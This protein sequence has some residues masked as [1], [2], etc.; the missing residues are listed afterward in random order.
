M[1]KYTALIFI[2]FVFS[3]IVPESLAVPF[4]KFVSYPDNWI[5]TA[6]PDRKVVLGG[7]DGTG[8]ITL[9][10][11]TGT[12]KAT[13]IEATSFSGLDHGDL[14]GLSDDDHPQYAETGELARLDGLFDDHVA[15]TSVHF[16]DPGFALAASLQSHE[17]DTGI[18]W[19]DPG[20]ALIASLDSHMADTDAHG[21]LGDH[22]SL[23]GLLDYD[24]PQYS[25]ASHI[26][27]FYDMTDVDVFDAPVGRSIYK[28][29]DG[30]WHDEIPLGV[31][32]NPHGD[33][34]ATNVVSDNVDGVDI[35]AH[36]T[37]S[38]AHHIQGGGGGGLWTDNTTYIMPAD[39]TVDLG[40]TDDRIPY[41]YAD[42]TNF[43]A[44]ESP[45]DS[46][47]FYAEWSTKAN[48][49]PN[50]YQH[51]FTTAAQAGGATRAT[52]LL[53][54]Y[55]W[56][57]NSPGF[58][59][60]NYEGTSFSRADWN[61]A[62]TGS[63]EI[64][65]DWSD[66]T[67]WDWYAYADTTRD[68]GVQIYTNNNPDTRGQ[69]YFRTFGPG[70]EAGDLILSSDSTTSEIYL[71]YDRIRPSITGAV[72]LGASAFK[73]GYVYA[74]NVVS[75]NVDGVDVSAHAAS[76][77]VHHAEVIS[78][79][80]SSITNI[81]NLD[82]DSTDDLVDSDLG[83]TVGQHYANADTDYTDDVTAS[84]GLS[85]TAALLYETE[86]DDFSELQAQV[87]DEVLLKSGTLTDTYICVYDSAG[88]DIVCNTDPGGL[89]GATSLDN[90][91]DPSADSVIDMGASN[92]VTFSF[93]TRTIII[94]EDGVA[95]SG[96]KQSEA[97]AMTITD[98]LNV[99]GAVNMPAICG[100]NSWALIQGAGGLG[101]VELTGGAETNTL[102]TTI[103]G[104]ESGEIFYG[105]GSNA[106]A[107]TAHNFAR[108]ADSITDVQVPDDI[109]IDGTANVSDASL[110]DAGTFASVVGTDV[111]A[112]TTLDI[113]SGA[114]VDSSEAGEIGIDTTDDQF[115]YYGAA[116]RVIPYKMENS[117]AI[118]STTLLENPDTHRLI[119]SQDG[120]TITDIHCIT[121]TGT[122]IIELM[123]Q[124]ATGTGDATV[125]AP[126]TCDSN[127]AE[128]DGSLS[129]GPIDAADWIAAR[130]GTAASSP[131]ILNVT[132]YYTVTRE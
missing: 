91:G 33:F 67:A 7:T 16:V 54:G 116:A 81:G 24:H 126:I 117:F 31:L 34:Y 99:H 83:V 88:T 87:S 96:T 108:I 27:Y 80:L 5:G 17:A 46:T 90:I 25:S 32:G 49:T 82:T 106:G 43:T 63:F 128:D 78:L 72:D 30:S 60:Y 76:S 50:F 97:Y 115:I 94:S 110:P 26:H 92:S 89:G 73:F 120:I 109:T 55:T 36:I 79:P 98:T 85:D 37:S 122:V 113:P 61:T 51:A 121:D 86:L 28:S 18:H 84:T 15:D 58:G 102:E 71:N 40:A 124:S 1:R 100:T 70:G 38:S 103:T 8:A 125:D 48:S 114:T 65:G 74:D 53:G 11:T 6:V 62:W 64:M 23:T 123:E 104:I 22:G 111:T 129:N 20:F 130:I 118:A 42:T 95:V 45:Q 127:G 132:W 52:T 57:W 56:N 75:D 29:S 3:I 131:T 112:V 77:S 69:I 105:T 41:I 35:S 68:E 14:L 66:G 13:V 19:A 12:I 2:L 4:P 119:K 10:P 93:D 9:D 101:C 107:F 21:G 39:Q 59:V 44:W 47:N